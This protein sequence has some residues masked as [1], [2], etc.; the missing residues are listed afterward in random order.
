MNF[1]SCFKLSSDETI[2]DSKNK[3]VKI[4]EHNSQASFTDDTQL[5]LWVSEA[6]TFLVE[7]G[8]QNALEHEFYQVK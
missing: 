1:K 6:Q 2:N 8:Y 5:W 7:Q 3:L 4:Q